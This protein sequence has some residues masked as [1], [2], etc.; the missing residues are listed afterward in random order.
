MWTAPKTSR[1]CRTEALWGRQEKAGFILESEQ[2][3]LVRAHA[4][5]GAVLNSTHMAQKKQW[6]RFWRL[7]VPLL[8]FLVSDKYFGSSKTALQNKPGQNLTN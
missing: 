4:L 5:V 6:G 8:T 3:F 2:D 1:R 7:C